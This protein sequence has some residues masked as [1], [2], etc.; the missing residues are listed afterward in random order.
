MIQIGKYN[1]L[2]IKRLTPHGAFLADNDN[3]E[4]LLPGIY[5]HD[6]DV[7]GNSIDVFV[8]RD[9]DDR[10]VATTLKPFVTIN[11]FAYLQVVS[12]NS[13]G[14]FLDWGLPKNILVPFSEQKIKMREGGIYLVY[15]YLDHN[16]GRIVASARINRF[17]GNVPPN[18]RRGTKVKALIIGKNDI[19]YT[20]IV[21][22]LHRGIVY[23][24]TV[25]KP[26]AI[27]NTIDAFVD[28]VREDGKIDLSL[29]PTYTAKRVEE[30]SSHILSIMKDNPNLSI[31]DNATPEQIKQLFECSKKDFKKAVGHLY[32]N[33]RIAILPNGNINLV[34]E[35]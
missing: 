19:G 22:N 13:V 21:D 20:A 24:N 26:L 28:K 6:T 31:N 3:N 2:T 33:R 11:T 17:L 8:Y 34:A 16:T 32:N 27:E 23:S 30:L 25:Y 4:I 35:K 18:Y 15:V 7:P 9:S 1:T 12:V 29:S 14:A 10:P 5:L